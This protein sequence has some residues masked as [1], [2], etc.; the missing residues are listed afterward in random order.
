[1]ARRNSIIV[2]PSVEYLPQPLTRLFHL[3]V[4]V[5]GE[6][7]LH[8]L[9]EAGHTL[10]YPF[11]SRTKTP[12]P[13]SSAVMRETRKIKRLRSALP[14][15]AWD[16]HQENR[17]LAQVHRIT[18]TH[19]ARHQ[20]YEELPQQELEGE[21][22]AD[23]IAAIRQI[24]QELRI[25][26]IVYSDSGRS[27]TAIPDDRLPLCGA[28]QK[29]DPAGMAGLRVWPWQ[30]CKAISLPV[31]WGS[32]SL[33]NGTIPCLPIESSCANSVK[34]C[35]WLTS[36]STA[37]ARSPLR[38]SNQ[39]PHGS[40]GPILLLRPRAQ[41][42]TTNGMDYAM[43]PPRAS[44]IALPATLRSVRSSRNRTCTSIP[45]GSES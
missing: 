34:H 11:T 33:T 10:G 12:F 35:G 2:Q 8:A 15:L 31:H 28:V 24:L 40:K 6:L 22:H 21:P 29:S 32:L 30:H 42:A 45:S 26:A 19:P 41:Q 25:P 39:T 18:Q 1:M 9:Q 23:L 4:H 43:L 17:I 13:C 5:A 37:L 3:T 16:G 27:F 44:P 7:F 36:N 20:R 14:A 38:C